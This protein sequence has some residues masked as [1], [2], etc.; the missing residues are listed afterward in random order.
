MHSPY[1]AKRL[2]RR[3][4][5]KAYLQLQRLLG[6][7]SVQ[8]TLSAGRQLQVRLLDN[9]AQQILNREGFERETLRVMRNCVK[10]GMVALD[11][12]ANL[13]Y[14]TVQLADW[15][16]PSGHVV[17][18]EPN[19]VMIQELEHNVRLND[20]QN[21]TIKPFALS[22]DSGEIAFHCPPPGFEGHGSIRPNR[23]F[24]VAATIKVATRPLDDVLAEMQISSVDFIK[25]DVEG[26]ER[27][28]FRGAANLLSGE[29]KPLLIF[30]C[31]ETTCQAFGHCVLD[32]LKEVENYG[33]ELEEI[34]HAIWCARPA[35]S[36]N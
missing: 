2:G 33:Y 25:V 31:A 30:E 10:T 28:L 15:V 17:A 21:V 29:R 18:F 3:F 6:R 22:A 11:I 7:R 27:S 34:D 20:L 4:A 26:A 9:L 19:P 14:Y 1:N 13:G 32:V 24:A 12:G 8:V 36:A 5:V 16:G 35:A 23:T